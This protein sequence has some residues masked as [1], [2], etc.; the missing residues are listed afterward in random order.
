MSNCRNCQNSVP[1]YQSFCSA[2]GARQFV[3]SRLVK[4]RGAKRRAKRGVLERL[5]DFFS[6]GLESEADKHYK[7]GCELMIFSG[8]SATTEFKE[9]LRL[10]PRNSRYK[11]ALATAYW[12][13]GMRQDR[14][15]DYEGAIESLNAA[16]DLQPDNPHWYAALAC[17]YKHKAELKQRGGLSPSMFSWVDQEE[18]RVS[19]SPEDV[20]QISELYE[21]ACINIGI[22]LRLD[23]TDVTSYMELSGIMKQIGKEREVTDNLREALAIVN[24]AIQADNTDE[25]SYSER[26]IIFE[27]L[28]EIDLAI[29]DLERNLTFSTSKA[30]IMIT[31]LK[32]EQLRERKTKRR[33]K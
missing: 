23:P 4:K 18:A 30:N 28:G 6:M 27:E 12:D 20:D 1:R 9:A 14:T 5:K 31:K 8:E 32:M 10:A 26:A 17:C 13:W 21:D 3:S 11:T 19:F 33:K 24:K 25:M 16:I 2:C 7:A 22:A 29:A 15:G